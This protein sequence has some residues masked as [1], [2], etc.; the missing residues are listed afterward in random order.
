MITQ[1]DLDK[2]TEM[3]K[4]LIKYMASNPKAFSPHAKIIIDNTSLE[5]FEGA[6]RVVDETF[7]KQEIQRERTKR[8]LSLQE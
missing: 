3:G 7:L 1:K 5:V 4:P 8:Q 2:L 6:A